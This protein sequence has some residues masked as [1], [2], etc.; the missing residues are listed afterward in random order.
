MAKLRC[1]ASVV[2]DFMFPEAG[3]TIKGAY[4][5]HKNN[6]VILDVT[7]PSIPDDAEWINVEVT[8]HIAKTT[9]KFEAAGIDLPLNVRAR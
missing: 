1:T 7:G 8:K 5:D 4:F 6:C 9:Y 2:A 3:V